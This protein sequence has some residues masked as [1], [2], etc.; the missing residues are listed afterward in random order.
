MNYRVLNLDNALLMQELVMKYMGEEVQVLDATELGPPLRMEC[1]FRDW[2]RLESLLNETTGSPTDDALTT[3]G[4]LV[5]F[6]GSNDFHHITLSLVRRFRQP[7]NLLMFDNHPDWIEWYP[8][9]H[10][11]CW[12]NHASNLPT[13]QQVWHC[14]GRSGEFEDPSIQMKLSTP[15]KLLTGQNPKIKVFPTCDKFVGNRWDEVPQQRLRFPR[16]DRPV[17]RERLLDL[18]GPYKEVLQQYPLYITLDKDVMRREFTL[19]NWNSGELS[20]DETLL[21]IETLIELSG[22]RLMAMDITGDF[23]RVETHGVYRAFLHWQ[24]HEDSENNI[25][26]EVANALNQRT[27]LKILRSVK[28]ACLRAR[29][30]PVPEEAPL[31]GEEAP[32]E[33]W[34]NQ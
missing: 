5:T 6:Y 3:N 12:L 11:G 33:A 25:P 27:N 18:F 7:F 30:L 2:N 23:T 17:T 19:Q 4:P 9:L 16:W 1:S 21:I 26:Q 8:G 13:V 22:G 15:W 24:Q 34:S 28:A 29:G 14:G 32:L 31:P 10:C 20:L